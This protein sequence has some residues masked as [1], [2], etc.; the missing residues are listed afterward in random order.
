MNNPMFSI[1]T[2]TYN[3]EKT[4]ER[5]IKSVLAQTCKDYEY[6]IVDGASKDSTIDIVKKY[7]P[8]FE[9]R[10]KWKSEPDKGIYNAMNKGIERSS[11]EI[12]GIVNSDDWI[13]PNALSFISD[14]ANNCDNLNNSVFCASMMFH[15]ENGSELL[16]HANE[17]KFWIGAKRYS[18]NR[19]LFHPA[20]YVPKAV[21]ER[22]GLF[23]ERIFVSADIDFIFRC[24]DA[25]VNFIFKDVLVCHMT[26]GGAS[27]KISLD[28]FKHDWSIFL[29]N[30]GKKGIEFYRL[31]YV[32]YFVLFIKK[33]TPLSFLKIYRKIKIS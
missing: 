9:G 17:N 28:I 2:I 12:M 25:G 22:Y 18:L 3:S 5:T 30:R 7:E 32:R 20:M 23:D 13:E 8:L 15:Y 27:N 6:I 19:G 10:M 21:Y 31:L 26:D 4:V 14:I 33:F 16:Y 11:G 29:S 1:I 24:F